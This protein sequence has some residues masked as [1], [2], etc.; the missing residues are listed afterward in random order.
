MFQYGDL[1]NATQ[2]FGPDLPNIK[3]QTVRRKPDRVE[4]DQHQLPIPRDYYQLNNFVT[5]TADMMMMYVNTFLVTKSRKIQLIT[6]AHIPTRT[7]K[8]LSSSLNKVI[9]YYQE[10]AL[11]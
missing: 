6:E 11:L 3:G 8:Q 10:P 1:V 7:V 4:T 9:K 2:M 5:L